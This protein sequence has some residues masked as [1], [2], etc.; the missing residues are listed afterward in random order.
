MLAH[1]RDYL[2][3]QLLTYGFPDI[4]QLIKELDLNNIFFSHLTIVSFLNSGDKRFLIIVQQL[5]IIH[6]LITHAT[7]L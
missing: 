1:Q 2:I 3:R 7:L 6:Y 5:R 4:E